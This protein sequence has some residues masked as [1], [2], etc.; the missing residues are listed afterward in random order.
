VIN[1]FPLVWAIMRRHAVVSITFVLL[2]ALAV[3][4]GAAITAQERA[5]RTGSA[6]AS[7]KFDM[8]VGAPG[9]QIDLLLRVV[10][11]QRG[12][13]ELLTGDAERKLLSE[14]RADF[15]APIGFGDNYQ[16]QPI[17]GTIPQLTMHLS[18]DHLAE[19]RNFDALT[20][21]VVGADADLKVGDSFHATHGELEA[22]EA[23]EEHEEHA[24]TV[25][26]VGRMAPTGTPWDRAILTPIELTWVMHDLGTGHGDAPVEHVGPPFDL[27]S[28]PGIPAAVVKPKT[29]AAAY[30]LRSEYR[31]TETTAF[32]PAEV[33]VQLYALIGDVRIVMSGLAIATEVLLVAAILAGILMLMRL[34]RQRF[35][36]LRALGASRGY[37]L[38]VAWTFSFGLIAV[39]SA[40]GLG[41]AAALVG[42]VSGVFSQASGI[43]MVASIGWPEISLAL[44]LTAIGAVLAI[45]PAALL[46]RRPV[47]E[48]LRSA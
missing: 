46:Y 18:G 2:I 13:V 34:Y 12:A 29:V 5:L 42:A 23:G 21:A 4:I 24:Q 39:G 17:I 22:E 33:L 32:F 44:L 25:T 27:A 6:R 47:V 45:L 7:D 9:S 20:E 35:A 30:G 11:L 1:P 40:L 37:V 48:A 36:V 3:G 41:V 14:P 10:F 28:V 38:A 15:V 16:G 31:T 19:G 8:V 26:V 43:A